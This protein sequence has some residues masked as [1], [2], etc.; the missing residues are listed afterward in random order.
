MSLG[1]A[2]A[3]SVTANAM[4]RMYSNMVRLCKANKFP[5]ALDLHMQLIEFTDSLF[6]EGSPAGVK[7]ALHNMGIVQNTV[8]MP[9]V[10]VTQKHYDYIASLVKQLQ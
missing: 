6:M 10:P 4:P 8:R 7:A 2:G 9:L 1:A 3:I 5:E